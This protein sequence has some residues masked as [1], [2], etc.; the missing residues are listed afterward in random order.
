MTA[1]RRLTPLRLASGRIVH[2]LK[3][4]LQSILLQADL[5]RDGAAASATDRTEIPEAIAA[6]AARMAVMLEDL[7]SFAEGDGGRLD[8]ESFPLRS[9]LTDV[10]RSSSPDAVQLRVEGAEAIVRADPFRLRQ[11]LERLVAN[12]REAV[13]VRERPEIAARVRTRGSHVELE[14]IDN[15]PGF[16]GDV[17]RWFEP[18][19]T[20]RPGSMGLG[21]TIA[22][23]IVERHGGRIEVVAGEAEG[24]TVRVLLPAAAANTDGHRPTRTEVHPA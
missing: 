4:P 20:S 22:R 6:E 11:A 24:A 15:G 8:L 13:A 19:A 21:L 12:A 1:D 14:L 5:L 16:A 2:T 18:F 23:S 3:N 7:T 10:A 9:L 17:D